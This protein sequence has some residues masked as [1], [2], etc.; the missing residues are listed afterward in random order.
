MPAKPT[1][2]PL[3]DSDR[4][5]IQSEACGPTIDNLED[6][7]ASLSS[8][9]ELFAAR[10]QDGF[11]PHG[12]YTVLP[13]NASGNE[14]HFQGF[15]RLSSGPYFVI[16]G[17][18]WKTPAS[19]LFVFKMGSQSGN[20]PWKSNLDRVPENDELVA[21]IEVDR[22]MW[23]AGGM[24][25]CGGILAVPVEC[26]KVD[27]F[28][29]L[30]RRMRGV[31]LPDC[32]EKQRSRI[33]FYYMGDPEQPKDMGCAID[34]DDRKATCVALT[35]LP[36]DRYLAAVQSAVKSNQERLDFYLSRS[37]S[38][39]EGWHAPR[40]WVFD[41]GEF[42]GF[43][44]INFVWQGRPEKTLYLIGLHNTSSKAPLE[45]G[46]N[47]AVLYRVKLGPLDPDGTGIEVKA[48]VRAGAATF[49]W[50]DENY[51]MDAGAAVYV[52]D[53]ELIVYSTH[54]YRSGGAVRFAQFGPGSPPPA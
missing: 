2:A 15:N 36:D 54:H 8:A 5:K 9:P 49:D 10:D 34:R 45:P 23:H 50:G 46:N 17:G 31:R 51:N 11:P 12:R 44:A 19:H 25:T 53:G 35:R 22:E 18:D 16:S 41:E 33:V 14:N 21:T 48:I 13:E 43:Q 29:S 37:T 42:P 38:I 40:Q 28:Q 24:D 1:P 7:V 32:S 30:L 52:D 20:G 27:F 26:N 4:A 39:W 3:S 47:R 6:A